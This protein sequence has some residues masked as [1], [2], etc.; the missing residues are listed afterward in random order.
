MDCHLRIDLLRTWWGVSAACF[1]FQAC[2][3]LWCCSNAFAVQGKAFWKKSSNKAIMNATLFGVL[4]A[5]DGFLRFGTGDDSGN[6]LAIAIVHATAGWLFWGIL[7]AQFCELFLSVVIAQA[8]M[9]KGA[10]ADAMKA[11]TARMHSL[12]K[13]Q[14]FLAAP[15][16]IV[17]IIEF[18]DRNPEHHKILSGVYYA[19]HCFLSYFLVN[20]IA[21]PVANSFYKIL[22]ATPEE[23]QDAKMKVLIGKVFIFCRETRNAGYF[24]TLCTVSFFFFPFLWNC[25][26]YQIVFAWMS[27]I[28]LLCVAAWITSPTKKS[29]KNGKVNPATTGHTTTTMTSSE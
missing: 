21:L 24:N 27:A 4:R 28:P 23:S 25:Q 10:N 1:V 16:Y 17:V 9:E 22:Q 15:A 19:L 2:F 5:I 6:N 3:S 8:K 12:I 7:S 26:A 14:K 13:I 18:F 29:G 11:K 20:V